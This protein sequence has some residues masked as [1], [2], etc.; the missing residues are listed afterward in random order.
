M[1]LLD[2]FR[3]KYGSSSDEAIG[4]TYEVFNRDDE[5]I[6]RI[7]DDYPRIQVEGTCPSPQ[8]TPHFNKKGFSGEIIPVVFYNPLEGKY[9]C[10][11]AEGRIHTVN[12]DCAG[13]VLGT[14]EA[15]RMF[16]KYHIRYTANG[17]EVD[18]LILAAEL[19]D[20]YVGRV[21][22]DVWPEADRGD[23]QVYVLDNAIRFPFIS[24]AK[25][26][27]NL[28]TK[29]NFV[30]QIFIPL[31]FRN[32]NLYVRTN[33]AGITGNTIFDVFIYSQT[34]PPDVTYIIA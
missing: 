23:Y 19:E 31:R 27:S 24:D 21:M 26:N 17:N 7:P 1:S 12:L 16:L 3:K 25:L 22:V 33:G 11:D 14:S 20:L 2:Y 28:N 34:K 4:E 32:R 8:I 10:V 15:E 13:N 5:Q 30:H 29:K 6:G 18:S 9:A